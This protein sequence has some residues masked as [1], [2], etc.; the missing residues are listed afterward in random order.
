VCLALLAE[1]KEGSVE[2]GDHEELVHFEAHRRRCR[3]LRLCRLCRLCRL[4]RLFQRLLLVLV[5]VMALPLAMLV[6]I[7]RRPIGPC[8]ELGAQFLWGQ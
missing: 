3:R 4:G 6:L 8:A 2:A 5:L 1:H 7:S